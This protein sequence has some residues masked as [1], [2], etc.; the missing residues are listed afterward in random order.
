[1]QPT[2]RDVD[3]TNAVS[4]DGLVLPTRTKCT[5]EFASEVETVK[6]HSSSAPRVQ[7]VVNER[8]PSDRRSTIFGLSPGLRYQILQISCLAAP[9]PGLIYL[10][11][12]SMS[13]YRKSLESHET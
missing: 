7:S 11:T 4:I 10:Q 6:I 13:L 9:E 3:R 5:I 12:Y 2:P 1:V 8:L